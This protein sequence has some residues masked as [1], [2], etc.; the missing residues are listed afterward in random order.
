MFDIEKK[1]KC[2]DS[3]IFKCCKLSFLSFVL[4]L[5]IETFQFFANFMQ[6]NLAVLEKKVERRVEQKKQKKGIKVN[7]H[8]KVK[9]KT[10]LKYKC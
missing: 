3:F 9:K 8:F 4:L 2:A 10:K 1:K 5:W 7:K 6:W